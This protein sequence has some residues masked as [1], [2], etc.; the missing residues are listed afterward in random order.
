MDADFA[1]FNNI[2]NNNVSIDLGKMADFQ[3]YTTALSAQTSN[4][5]QNAEILQHKIAFMFN[6]AKILS[7]EDP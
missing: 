2:Q 1:V 4:N 6:K 7:F 5:F 3:K